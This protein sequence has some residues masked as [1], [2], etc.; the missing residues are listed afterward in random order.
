MKTKIKLSRKKRGL[1]NIDYLCILSTDNSGK[2]SCLYEY[3]DGVV[4]SMFSLHELCSILLVQKQLN[5]NKYDRANENIERHRN[6]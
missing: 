2:L 1:V 3:R 5:S 6:N 4:S